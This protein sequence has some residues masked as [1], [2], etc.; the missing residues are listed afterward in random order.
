[1]GWGRVPNKFFCISPLTLHTK[2]T[3]A[4]N[5]TARQHSSQHK[6]KAVKFQFLMDRNDRPKED[7][8]KHFSTAGSAQPLL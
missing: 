6:E 3:S 8:I 4:K 2:L 7:F 5:K 1:V